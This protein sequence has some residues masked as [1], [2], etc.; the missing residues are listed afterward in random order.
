MVRSR[1]S[2]LESAWRNR[3]SR[4]VPGEMTVTSFCE[5]EGISAP[6][7]YLWRK[8]LCGTFH[9]SE[10]AR[11]A[12]PKSSPFMELAVTGRAMAQI[13][14]PNGLRVH[15]ASLDTQ[16]MAAAIRAA[17]IVLRETV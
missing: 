4:F 10:N 2:E 6:S 17:S 12:R 13:E 8:R 14:L 7:F 3:M 11:K 1:S 9:G 15:L 5:R 16:S